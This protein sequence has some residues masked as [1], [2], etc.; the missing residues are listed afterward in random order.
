VALGTGFQLG[1]EVGP[2]TRF[3]PDVFR[4]LC[5]E[6]GADYCDRTCYV[7]GDYADRMLLNAQ[8]QRTLWCYAGKELQQEV[9]AQAAGSS[10]HRNAVRAGPLVWRPD[11]LL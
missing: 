9:V 7:A 11:R 10:L 4:D 2:F 1:T 6:H 8:G 5:L 3:F